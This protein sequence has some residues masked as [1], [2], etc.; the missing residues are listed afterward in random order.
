MSVKE[1][2][3]PWPDD[4]V[5]FV[6]DSFRMKR[7]S[8]ASLQTELGQ[9]QTTMSNKGATK[10]SNAIDTLASD[11]INDANLKTLCCK[12]PVV[13]LAVFLVMHKRSE[14]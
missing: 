4:E 5:N 14:Q 7:I 13:R 11:V 9:Q 1:V 6:T 2:Y 8:F 12:S 10:M 3:S